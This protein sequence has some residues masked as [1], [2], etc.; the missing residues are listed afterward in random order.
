MKLEIKPGMRLEFALARIVDGKQEQ[1]FSEY[2][3]NVGPVVGEYGGS[4]AGGVSIVTSNI[5]EE[6]QMGAMFLWPSAQAY[7]DLHKDARFVKLKPVRDE[8]FSYFSNGHF[9]DAPAAEI[10]LHNEMDYLIAITDADLPGVTP[11]LDAPLTSD[12]PNQSHAG[13]RLIIAEWNDAAEQASAPVSVR[14]RINN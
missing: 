4:N 14:A 12:S 8:A 11:L 10:E 13:C 5:V 3:P 1:L 2:F 9:F 7:H 6:P